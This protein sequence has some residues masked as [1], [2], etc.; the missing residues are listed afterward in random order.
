MLCKLCRQKT[1]TTMDDFC[2]KCFNE[3]NI[4]STIS[5]KNLRKRKWQQLKHKN[6]INTK[7]EQGLDEQI[8]IETN[9]TKAM[10]I[11]MIKDLIGDEK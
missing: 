4:F 3:I 6:N 9:M 2:K 7:T 10:R 8:M 1:D 11:K 5:N